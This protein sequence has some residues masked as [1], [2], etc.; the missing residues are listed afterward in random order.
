M[1]QH[2][3][4]IRDDNFALLRIYDL[5]SLQGNTWCTRLIYR[6]SSVPRYV[7]ILVV[8]LAGR[9][10]LVV[11][12]GQF[13]FHDSILASC[14]NLIVVDN[15]LSAHDDERPKLTKDRPRRHDANGSTFV[16]MRNK[17]SINKISLL[18]IIYDD[19][20]ELLVFVEEKVT[21]SKSNASCRFRRKHVKTLSSSEHGESSAPVISATLKIPELID[22][23]LS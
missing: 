17:I 8:L 13:S 15:S 16:R 3:V 9:W 19:F 21:V 11:R 2:P 5:A 22:F 7:L 12:I 6:A 20:V 23:S 4:C 1:F 10:K 14:L 18:R